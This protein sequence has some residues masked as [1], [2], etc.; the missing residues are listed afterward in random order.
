[1][2][3]LVSG[4]ACRAEING[5]WRAASV[6][7]VTPKTIVV[8]IDG[9]K[10]T[11]P[12]ART[13]KLK[14]CQPRVR[15]GR[16]EVMPAKM[17]GPRP[18]R[19]LIPT[20]RV[21]AV[22]FT[23]PCTHGDYGWQLEDAQQADPRYG[24]ALHIYNENLHQQMDKTNNSA[25]GGNAIARPHRPAGKAIGMPTGEYGGFESLDERCS[26]FNITAKQAIDDAAAEIVEQVVDNP[27]RYDTV[28]YCVNRDDP[29]LIGAG[30]FAIDRSVREY[31]SKTI[32]DLPRAIRA[33]AI[34]KRRRMRA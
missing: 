25:G 9:S 6:V 26:S 14:K 27:A 7:K 29:W 34:D 31:I 24:R 3:T 17:T 13:Q 1:M 8:S 5:K 2:P 4:E 10:H 20:V 12:Y 28:F 16:A 19:A 32:H 18:A 33:R 21:E 30:I 11:L 22:T 23:R 15:T